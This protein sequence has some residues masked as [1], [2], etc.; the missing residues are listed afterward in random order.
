MIGQ[1][2]GL[3][4]ELGDDPA[5]RDERVGGEREPGPGATAGPTVADAEAIRGADRRRQ[6]GLG[7]ANR[8]AEVEPQ[9]QPESDAA[10]ALGAL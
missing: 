8:L 3:A 10:F 7:G 4:A 1:G 5:D 9:R 2:G 6:I